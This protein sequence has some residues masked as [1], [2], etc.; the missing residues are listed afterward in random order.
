[1][2][3]ADFGK[4]FNPEDFAPVKLDGS[5]IQEDQGHN[6][7]ENPQREIQNAST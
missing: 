5:E 4:Q 7:L 2:A 1:M 6:T 3:D